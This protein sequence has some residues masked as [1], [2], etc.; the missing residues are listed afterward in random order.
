MSNIRWLSEEIVLA[1]HERSLRDHGGGSGL[2]DKGLLHGA[3]AKPKQL[4]A[5]QEPTVFEIAAAYA[6]GLGRAHAFIDGNKRTAFFA[7]YVFLGLNGFELDADEAEA[8]AITVDVATGQLPESDF[9]RWL[10][11]MCVPVGG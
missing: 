2:R 3:L 11:A 6:S 5:Y 9:A 4:A 10:E 7:A 8:A 1:L